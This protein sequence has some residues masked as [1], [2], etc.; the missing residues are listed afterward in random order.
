M[1]PEA[2]VEFS[3]WKSAAERRIGETLA[4]TWRLD[5]ILGTGGT[6]TV[7]SASEASGRRV[8]IKM[9]RPEYSGNAAARARLAREARIANELAA[10]GAV[11][12]LDSCI[13]GDDLF[14]VMD[15]LEGETLS[16]RASARG[17]LELDEALR[18]VEAV[19][20]VLAAAHARGIVHRDV[21]PQNVFV[22]R[23]GDV[24][25]LDFGL[26]RGDGL[27][28]IP[29]GIT[30]SGATLGTPAYMA[31]EQANGRT[32][33][34]DARTDVWC[35]GATLYTVLT[36]QHVHRGETIGESL[37]L[38][39]SQP[40]PPIEA[41][42]PD[43]PRAIS[44]V[45]ARALA[46]RPEDR[47]ADAGAML[48]ALR[49]ARETVARGEPSQ[50]L[51]IQAQE[52]LPEESVGAARPSPTRRS[53]RAAVLGAGVFISV[54]VAATAMA[55]GPTRVA[56]SAPV[57][58]SA[59]APPAPSPRVETTRA[60]AAVDPPSPPVVSPSPPPSVVPSS[61]ARATRPRKV[62]RATQAEAPTH[63]SDPVVA[64]PPPAP[65]AE[66]QVQAPTLD[67]MLDHRK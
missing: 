31:P 58:L 17:R 20:T 19:L 25:L 54:C 62:I 34:V 37:V 64:A 14:L 6:S 21:K 11:A 2:E 38:A 22:T 12:V 63:V 55:W 1:V 51:P 27:H 9:L 47:F 33:D 50:R 24:R 10:E 48:A 16:A 60:L 4:G 65:S 43:L 29:D 23:E 7:F 49:E 52:T 46:F 53:T 44:R 40:A 5:S 56:V 30:R 28:A 13:V 45:V 32:R 41:H 3:E 36:G 39:G 18:I 66:P 15:L 8:A 61:S 42:L 67:D 59:F 26:A 57:A 35:T